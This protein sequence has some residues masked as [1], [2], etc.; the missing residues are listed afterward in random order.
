MIDLHALIAAAA[1]PREY[2]SARMIAFALETADVRTLWPTIRLEVATLAKIQAAQWRV[3][4]DTLTDT[5]R[6]AVRTAATELD[7]AARELEREHA[8]TTWRWAKRLARDY[9]DLGKE[10]MRSAYRLY[11]GRR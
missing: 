1:S 8:R 3:D 9:P 5:D 11:W 2:E 4:S 10:S 6:E 7:E